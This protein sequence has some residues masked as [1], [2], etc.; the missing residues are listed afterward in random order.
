MNKNA[1]GWFEIPVKDLDRAI[2]FYETV[3]GIRLSKQLIGQAEMALFP[4][5][6]DGIGTSGSL[7]L[8]RELYNPSENGILI[9][10]TATSSDL[11]I[12]LG[13]VE[14]AGGKVSIPRKQISEEIGFMAVIIDS[15]GNRIA[16][17]S[18]K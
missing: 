16:L 9:Y 10:F 3:F 2:E 11:S 7:V 5:I 13:I 8:Y 18:R 14:V 12:E 17:H 4:M 6:E 1:V 15:E